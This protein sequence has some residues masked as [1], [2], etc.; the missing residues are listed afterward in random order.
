MACCARIRADD[1]RGKG[2]A[3]RGYEWCDALPSRHGRVAQA[4]L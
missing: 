3:I 4:V 1:E 2:E